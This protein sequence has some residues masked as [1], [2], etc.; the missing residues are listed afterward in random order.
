MVSKKYDTGQLLSSLDG[1]DKATAPD[2]FYGKL[3]AR[4]QR[5]T[6]NTVLRRKFQPAYA[7]AVLILFLMLNITVLLKEKRPQPAPSNVEAFANA[8]GLQPVNVYE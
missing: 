6:D 4:L 7:L 3:L 8:Y 1:M 5:G 2:F